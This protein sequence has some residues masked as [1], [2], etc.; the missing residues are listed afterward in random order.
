[1]NYIQRDLLIKLVT[2]SIVVT[3]LGCSA[4]GETVGQNKG[5][6]KT[7]EVPLGGNTYQTGPPS[8]D[9]I[10]NAGIEGWQHSASNFSVF[11]KFDRQVTVDVSLRGSVDAGTSTVEIL[12]GET[13]YNVAISSQSEKE[14]SVGK[15]GISEAGYARFDIKGVEKEGDTYAHISDLILKVPEDVKVTYV[16][17]NKKNRFYWGRRGPSVHLGYGFPE[18]TDI[19]WFYSEVTVPKGQDPVGSYFMANGFGE[20]YFGIQVNASDERRVLFSVWSPYQTDNPEEIPE[21][22]RIQVL[23]KGEGVYTGKFGNEGSGGQSYWVYPWEAGTTYR[24]LNGARPDGEGNTIYTAYFYLPNQQQ[25]KLIAQ[26][27]RP[28]T[29]SWYTRPHSFL[30]NFV[31]TNGYLGR[32]AWYHNQWARDKSGQWHQITEARFMGDDIA[33][34]AY[35][36]DFAGGAEEGRF[37]LR[38]GGFFDDHVPLNTTLDIQGTGQP[39]TVN[40]DILP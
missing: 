36:T 2:M 31:D 17:D 11:I 6:V 16:R 5:I 40:F 24:F 7:V 20:G 37:F 4:D 25:W 29:D 27:K 3:V 13:V 18:E 21:E 19:E 32:L 39:P 10:S 8:G 22:Q 12:H 26:F 15:V 34:R 33:Q 9:E 1:M 14:V 35:R 23:K 30:E 38:N 28:Q